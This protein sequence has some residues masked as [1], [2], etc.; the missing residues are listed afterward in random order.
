[1][2][3]IRFMD[4]GGWFLII[5]TVCLMY[6]SF[7]GSDSVTYVITIPIGYLSVFGIYVVISSLLFP[8]ICFGAWIICLLG[9]LG[10]S[11]LRSFRYIVESCVFLR[12]MLN[13]V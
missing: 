13:K 7:N 11:N 10:S 6:F 9:M 1:M 5:S 2:M 3:K 12:V 8:S 4:F